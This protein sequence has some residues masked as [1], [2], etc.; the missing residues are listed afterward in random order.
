M[1]LLGS[2]EVFEKENKNAKRSQST[3]MED[4]PA[5]KRTKPTL[6]LDEKSAG[7]DHCKLFVSSLK[8]IAPKGIEEKAYCLVQTPKVGRKNLYPYTPT[9]ECSSMLL[10][11]TNGKGDS[12]KAIESPF[13]SFWTKGESSLKS[14]DSFGSPLL[15]AKRLKYSDPFLKS[16]DSPWKTQEQSKDDNMCVNINKYENNGQKKRNKSNSLILLN[17][18]AKTRDIFQ[19]DILQ[20]SIDYKLPHYQISTDSMKRINKDTMSHLL[21]GQ[22]DDS[23]SKYI[24]VDCRF[25][26]EYKGGHIKGAL[27]LPTIEA[28]ENF[29][30]KDPILDDGIAVILH[31][32]HS[33]IRAPSLASHIRKRDREL[34]IGNYPNLYYPELYILEGGYSGFYGSFKEQCQPQNYV[35]MSDHKHL[36]ACKLHINGFERQFKRSKS[37]YNSNLSSALTSPVLGA[38]K[39]TRSKSI[40]PSDLFN[41]LLPRR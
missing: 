7:R 22:Y 9:G 23:Y 35:P 26:Y 5:H 34:N 18:E 36:A 2:I 14:R 8:E 29:F 38:S 4:S 13:D 32:E 17:T 24:I 10:S 41:A 6:D 20:H 19:T 3:I 31:C 11:D 37:T 12:A 27:N 28:L 15:L 25:P 40:M 1:G 39:L 21:S 16:K 30:F 33:E